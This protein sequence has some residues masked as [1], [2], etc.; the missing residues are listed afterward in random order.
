MQQKKINLIYIK[1]KFRKNLRTGE[2]ELESRP[3]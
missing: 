3:E 2:N 1:F